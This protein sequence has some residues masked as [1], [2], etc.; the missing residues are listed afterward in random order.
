MLSHALRFTNAKEV[1]LV[2]KRLTMTNELGNAR[3]LY[4]SVESS[5][6]RLQYNAK[7]PVTN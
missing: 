1:T 5:I 2:R 3:A 6:E 7:A 4:W